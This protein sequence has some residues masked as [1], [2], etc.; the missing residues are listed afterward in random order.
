MKSFYACD[1]CDSKKIEFVY[2]PIKSRRKLIMS[3]FVLECGLVQSF[4]KIDKG[5]YDNPEVSGGANW[6]TYGME[7]VLGLYTI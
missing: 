5:E 7:K 6:A 2:R 1:L 3:I 4:P